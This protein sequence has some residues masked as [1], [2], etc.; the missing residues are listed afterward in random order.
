MKPREIDWARVELLRISSKDWKKV[1]EII[2][3]PNHKAL[4]AAASDR[5]KALE[6]RYQATPWPR[7]M[8][9]PTDPDNWRSYAGENVSVKQTRTVKTYHAEP[10]R[11]QGGVAG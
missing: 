7:P 6:K 2:G 8:K 1:A 10:T 9:D 4:A 3:H 11:T 5:R